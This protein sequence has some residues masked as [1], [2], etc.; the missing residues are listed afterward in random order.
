[1]KPARPPV[2][3]VAVHQ[4]VRPR[5]PRRQPVRYAATHGRGPCDGCRENAVRRARK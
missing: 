3:R 5:E 1:M 4:Y 2:H